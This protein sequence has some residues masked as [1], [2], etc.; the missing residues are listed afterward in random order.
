[1]PPSE[2]VAV[3]TREVANRLADEH[4]VEVWSRRYRHQAAR[5]GVDGVDY[6]FVVGRGD[7]RLE[8]A[9][10]MFRPLFPCKRLMFASALYQPSFFFAIARELSYDPP[11]VIHIQNFSQAVPV[12]RVACPK[13]VIVLHERDD[14]L[15]SLS[16]ALLEPRLRLA[17]AVVGVSEYTTARIMQVFPTIAPRCATLSGG[18]DVGHFTPVDRRTPQSRLRLLTSTR[19]SPEKGTH[20]LLEAFADLARRHPHV[21]L[22]VIGPEALPPPEMLAKL[23]DDSRL[24][25]H[26]HYYESGGY[27]NH[28][29]ASLPPDLSSRV[30]FRGRLPHD[31]LPERFRAADIF[32]FPSLQDAFP[33]PILEAMASALPVV[34][35]MVGGITEMI[36][37]ERTG[38]LM[39]PHDAPALA[40]AIERLVLDPQLRRDLGRAG[41]KRAEQHS[42]YEQ[43]AMRCA[44]LYE[45]SRQGRRA[46]PWGPKAWLLATLLHI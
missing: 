10:T 25:Q 16:R 4:S 19:I 46:A 3:W 38:L 45:S 34:G 27:L 13:S 12:F 29:R 2:S 42:S 20:V 22:E 31:Q 21:E 9:L 6:R 33:S 8:Q 26:L 28:L 30:H 17:D 39:P 40:R 14:W 15:P 5:Q 37:H 7:Y 36:E 18:V 43:V 1:M 24:K 44:R 11:D 23:S 41:R 32:V 35:T